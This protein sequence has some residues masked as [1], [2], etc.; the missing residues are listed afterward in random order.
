MKTTIRCLLDLSNSKSIQNKL[1]PNSNHKTVKIFIYAPI[2]IVIIL[3][4]LRTKIF[5]AKNATR[6]I[7]CC[8]NKFIMVQ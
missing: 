3:E 4:L 8:A 6:L 1:F 2:L 5:I 7:V